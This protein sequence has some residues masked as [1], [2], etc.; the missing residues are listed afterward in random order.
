[1]YVFLSGLCVCMFVLLYHHVCVCV[2]RVCVCERGAR[3]FSSCMRAYVRCLSSQT[4][5]SLSLCLSRSDVAKRAFY[6]NTETNIGTFEPPFKRRRTDDTH[7]HSLSRSHTHDAAV[8]SPVLSLHSY[9]HAGCGGERASRP[10]ED[11]KGATSGGGRYDELSPLQ[12]VG[13]RTKCADA[14][15]TAGTPAGAEP[16]VQRVHPAGL[17]G[18]KESYDFHGAGKG[19]QDHSQH[20]QTRLAMGLQTASGREIGG[21]SMAGL[22]AG[23]LGRCGQKGGIGAGESTGE[24]ERIPDSEEEGASQDVVCID[25]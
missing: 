6:Y 13:W 4:S 2:A 5:L 3:T 24:V 15:S 18:G 22:A 19:E 20:L 14:E 25:D 1:M 8:R 23:S 7:T 21:K 16:N 10:R 17:E 12:A 9:A 11:G